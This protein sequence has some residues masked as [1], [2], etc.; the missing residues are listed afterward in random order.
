MGPQ[1]LARLKARGEPGAI[2]VRDLGR[3]YLLLA[4]ARRG[5]GV[6][7]GQLRVLAR[8]LAARAVEVSETS[9]L[10]LDHVLRIWGGYRYAG[11]DYAQLLR[12]V[13]RLSMLQRL[14]LIDAAECSLR[15]A[16]SVREP[17]SPEQEPAGEGL[18][19]SA[20][21]RL[22]SVSNSGK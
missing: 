6:S 22:S 14:A 13:A 18:P 12:R 19:Q 15:S 8:I 21:A 11:S 7:A 2:A 1:L 5:L 4:H 16:A 17:R 9:L 20:S 10:F 3:Y